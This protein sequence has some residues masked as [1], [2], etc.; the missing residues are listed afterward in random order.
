MGQ[1]HH[2]SNQTTSIEL[3]GNLHLTD[4][5][6]RILSVSSKT[7]QCWEQGVRERS[8]SSVRLTHIFSQ[9]LD[10]VCEIVG[11]PGITL[12]G[13]SIG[14]GRRKIVL[15]RPCSIPKETGDKKHGQV[16]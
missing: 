16:Q 13:V 3:A 11:L 15:D 12:K 8:M 7:A 9:C 1:R 10:V 2:V 5:E 4:D 14:Q 6:S